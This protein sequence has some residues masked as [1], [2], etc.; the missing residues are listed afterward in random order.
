MFD[1]PENVTW[2]NFDAGVVLLKL[3]TGNYYTLNESASLIWRAI[4]EG[5]SESEILM[6]ILTEYDC[7][8]KKAKDDMAEQ[9]AFLLSEELIS[10][11]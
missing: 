10:L 2:K 11:R 9:I 3:T 1:I 4:L 8:E 7:E 5:K 6:R